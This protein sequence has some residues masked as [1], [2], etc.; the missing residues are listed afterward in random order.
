[1]NKM[2]AAP[3][4]LSASEANGAQSAG[5]AASVVTARAAGAIRCAF[6]I[7]GAAMEMADPATAVIG[8][9]WPAGTLWQAHARVE[10]VALPAVPDRA[11]IPSSATT[12]SREMHAI[13]AS[14][15]TGGHQYGHGHCSWPSHRGPHLP[16]RQVSWQMTQ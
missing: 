10:L 7:V 11:F 6:G 12:A 13:G 14:E 8:T 1:M 9:A 2:G 15:G 3:T 4:F 16:G 5:A